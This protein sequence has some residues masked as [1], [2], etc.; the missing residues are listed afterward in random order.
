VYGGPPPTREAFAG[1][2]PQWDR[3]C[4]RFAEFSVNQ[5]WA[6]AEGRRSEG[7][8]VRRDV[9]LEAGRPFAAATLLSRRRL[10]LRLHYVSRGPLVLEEG[11]SR[12][13][14]E[15]R[16]ATCMAGYRGELGLLD[17]MICVLPQTFAEL[18]P[19]GVRAAGLS[20]LYSGSSAFGF[21]SIVSLSGPDTL[22]AGASSDWRNRLRRSEALATRVQES[23]DPRDFL[24]ARGLV[25]D[26]EQ[27]KAFTTNLPEAH[28]R[29]LASGP[30][31]LF[32]LE[33]DEGRMVGALLLALAGTRASR[34][35]AAVAPGATRSHPGI[36]RV[37]EVAASRWA[38]E[39]G[40]VRYDLEG[41]NP[42]D[43]G[44]TD[45]KL[46]IRGRLYCAAGTHVTSRPSLLARAASWWRRSPWRVP[47]EM[48]R[49]SKRYVLQ[50]LLRAASR[51]WIRWESFH[52]FRVD[53]AK[54]G[55]DLR[56]PGYRV[57]FLDRLD[58]EDF[59]FRLGTVPQLWDI[60]AELRPGERECGVLLAP[61][62][63]AAGYGLISW[64]Q[65]NLYE[66]DV[67]LPLAEGDGYISAVAVLP[68]FRGK[69][70]SAML[71]AELCAHVRR[72][73]GS[74]V[75]AIVHCDNTPSIRMVRRV[76]FE[77]QR[78]A[79]LRRFGPW[80]RLRWVDAPAAVAD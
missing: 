66:L 7:W 54:G 48:W 39:N 47:R 67:V 62:G 46:G 3:L 38:F 49:F 60:C 32:Y 4:A 71:M 44:V 30:S 22:R 2:G 12:E 78:T 24:R 40:A 33:D 68:E 10:G 9:W 80:R 27:S 64:K 57:V 31:R 15:R 13:E 11:T 50:L 77:V 16:L 26:L 42:F 53:L 34:L 36:G 61:D 35:M 37:L 45:Y 75:H 41:L 79:L 20:P 29:A 25:G 43:R 51:G 8:S 74:A 55:G 23:S 58:P 14:A 63:F 76:G 70:T 65:A 5:T 72:R 52:L 69:G 56:A 28:L 18:S 21:S 1:D 17:V 19:A 59:H 73:G 6:W